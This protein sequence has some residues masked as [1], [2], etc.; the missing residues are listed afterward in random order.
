MKQIYPD[1]YPQFHCLAGGC[2]DTCCKDWEV[3]VDED[4]MAFY[5][6]VTGPLGQRLRDAFC[7]QD[8]ETCFRLGTD[9]K[10]VLLTGDGLCPLQ[11]EFGEKGLCR[12][13]ASHPR[14]LEEY[15]A[16]QEI[17]LSI[18]CPEAAR[19]LLEHP[20]P[21]SFLT[22]Q[23]D[24]PVTTPNTLDPEVYFA[25]R[26][27]RDTA[28]TLIQ[29]RSRTI[30]DRLALVLLMAVR[31]QALLDAGKPEHTEALCTRFL[32]RSMQERQLLRLRRMRRGNAEF[33]PLWLLLRNMEHLT[34]RFPALLDACAHAGRPDAAFFDAYASRL[35]NLSVYFI[36][37]YVLKAAA[38]SRL[39]EKTAACVFH[40]LAV[41]RLFPHWDDASPDGFR[42]LC[43]LY[44]K[45]VEHSEENLELLYRSL[46][47]GA[48]RV[49]SLLALL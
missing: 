23:T 13:C 7:T 10:C 17:T 29:D 5:R 39:L 32:T 27:F 36:F 30:R 16:V 21:V 19:L 37:R 41:S 2:P 26:T 46:R 48:L 25:V 24:E 38:D 49:G 9:G 14:F 18:S 43:G 3:V 35:E 6:T 44:S 34:P 28:I 31:A 33:F 11:A 1:F 15:G 20:E 45:E 22:Q 42:A 12:I 40:V 47:R 4:A 8:G